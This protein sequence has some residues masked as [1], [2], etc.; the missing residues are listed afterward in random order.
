MMAGSHLPY[1]TWIEEALRGVVRKALAF[2]AEHGLVGP[3]H[4]YV[5][6]STGDRGVEMPEWL[7][8]Q[9]P[10]EMTIVLQHQF[11]DLV[12][13]DAMFA[14]T[15]RFHGRPA[16]LVV[17]FSSVQAFGDPGVNFGLQLHALPTAAGRKTGGEDGVAS[18]AE[19]TANPG[20]QPASEPLGEVIALDSFRKK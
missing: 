12:V 1:E 5:T 15:L 19:R 14:V 4:F 2:T 9:Y 3:H 13:E 18:P 17:P 6:F 7:R 20:T 10:G 16:R 11:S 8:A